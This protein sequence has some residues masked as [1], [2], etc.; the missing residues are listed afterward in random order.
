M[1]DTPLKLNLTEQIRSS[2][3]FT[4][5][6]QKQ[7]AILLADTNPLPLIASIPPVTNRSPNL[8]PKFP[9]PLEIFHHL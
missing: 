2:H 9:R 8:A 7:F 3:S 5:R 4:E 6:R 1:Q